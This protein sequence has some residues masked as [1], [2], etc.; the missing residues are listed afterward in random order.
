MLAAQSRIIGPRFSTAD[1]IS[2]SATFDIQSASFVEAQE[3]LGLS[4]SDE[5]WDLD[6]V[7]PCLE[8]TWISKNDISF[9]GTN[10]ERES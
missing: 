6:L 2:G 1:Q 3:V 5:F 9:T 10:L 7:S 4:V 8:G